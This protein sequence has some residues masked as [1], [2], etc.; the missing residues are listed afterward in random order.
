MSDSFIEQK[1][2]HRILNRNVGLPLAFGLLSAVFFCAIVYYLL[3]VATG[4]TAP[5]GAWPWR[6]RR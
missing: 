1:Q 4:S 3:S 5:S 2:F 6:T